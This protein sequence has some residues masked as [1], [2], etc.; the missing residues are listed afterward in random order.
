MPG[1][2]VSLSLSP[3]SLK[4]LKDYSVH[5]Q[6]AENVFALFAK[7]FFG[8]HGGF[9]DKFAWIDDTFETK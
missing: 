5:F 6:K 7:Q 8:Y 2:N 1:N 3:D 4:N 9:T